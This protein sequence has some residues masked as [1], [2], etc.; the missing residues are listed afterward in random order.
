MNSVR[1]RIHSKYF[2]AS[3]L[4]NVY[5]VSTEDRKI[6]KQYNDDD[7]NNMRTMIIIIRTDNVLSPITCS[8]THSV[9]KYQITTSAMAVMIIILTVTTISKYYNF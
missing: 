3:K 7:N 6:I 4:T 8:E 1:A 5:Y 2:G 9:R